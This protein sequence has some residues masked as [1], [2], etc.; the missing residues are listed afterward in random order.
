VKCHRANGAGGTS[1]PDLSA[2]GQVR[3]AR[4]FDPGGPNLAAIERSILDPNADIAVPHRVF[5]VVTTKGVSTR[6][7]LLNQ[8]TFS[9]QLLDTTQQLRSFAKSDLK[10]F[11][12]LPS[13]MPSYRGRLSQAQMNDLLTYLLTLKG[14]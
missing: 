4:G 7:R 6:G 5:E 12:F 14:Q 11:G 1:G 13:P 3:P 10:Q 9:L 8:D 2:I